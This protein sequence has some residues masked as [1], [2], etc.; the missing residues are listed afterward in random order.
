MQ[1]K[2]DTYLS[3]ISHVSQ[4]VLV[5]FAIFG[6][7]YTVRP[8]YQKELLSEDIASKQVELN[9]LGQ[10]LSKKNQQLKSQKDKELSLLDNI[11]DLKKSFVL[12]T[13]ELNSIQL[14]VANSKLELDKQKK[15]I[16]ALTVK[17]KKYLSD[18]YFENFSGLVFRYYLKKVYTAMAQD[19]EITPDLNKV[20]DYLGTPY[21]AIR[22]TL[23]SEDYN[24]FRSNKNVPD[25]LKRVIR[26][27]I[28]SNLKKDKSKLQGNTQELINILNAYKNKRDEIEKGKGV[29]RVDRMY[30][31]DK[32]F[33]KNID[34]IQREY[35]VRTMDYIKK[36]SENFR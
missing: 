13:D 6:Y 10:E 26:N 32:E 27:Y 16:N 18:T 25:S 14:Q 21:D 12:A 17:N 4:F 15:F 31:L 3:R 8:I 1:S 34:E 35:T 22:S 30:D 36:L 33:T 29:E 19:N 9:S 11:A 5:A 20:Q 28:E 24:F 2:I 7:F 23:D